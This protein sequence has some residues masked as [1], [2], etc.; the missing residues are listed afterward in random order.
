MRF[1]ASDV[2]V[3]PVIAGNIQRQPFYEKYVKARSE[4]PGTDLL[5]QCG[6]YCGYYTW[7]A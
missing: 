5:H 1:A 6:F 2:E 3:R 7:C 4:L